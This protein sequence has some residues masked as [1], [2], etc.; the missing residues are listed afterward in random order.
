MKLLASSAHLPGLQKL[1]WVPIGL[2]HSHLGSCSSAK[3]SHMHRDLTCA[4]MV[5]AMQSGSPA[6]ACKHPS[7]LRPPQ[8]ACRML[9]SASGQHVLT[10]SFDNCVLNARV[11]V[12]KLL[13]SWSICKPSVQTLKPWPHRL[14]P[15]PLTLELVVLDASG[16]LDSSTP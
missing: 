11:A 1:H 13:S 14:K 6:C 16:H 4:A 2:V 10:S 15:Q 8:L 12:R 7:A 9:P 3:Q 5:W